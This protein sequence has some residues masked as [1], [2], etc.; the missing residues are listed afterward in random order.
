MIVIMCVLLCV[1][2]KLLLLMCI[3]IIMYNINVWKYNND[4]INIINIIN[5]INGNNDW[6]DIIID[7]IND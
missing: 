6:N 7:N 3:N 5:I 1:D 2:V 4:N